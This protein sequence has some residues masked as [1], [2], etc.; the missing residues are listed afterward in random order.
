MSAIHIVFHNRKKLFMVDA[1]EVQ[2]SIPDSQTTLKIFLDELNTLEKKARTRLPWWFWVILALYFASFAIVIVFVWYILIACTVGIVLIL[3]ILFVH[4]VK[5]WRILR[6]DVHILCENYKSVFR[7][8]Y[9]VKN[10]FIDDSLPPEEHDFEGLA[11]LL[12]PIDEKEF[13]KVRVYG[14]KPV[15]VNNEGEY[16][17]E[18][19]LDPE[20]RKMTREE[21]K[22]NRQILNSR[23]ER[24]S[25]LS[26]NQFI[27][28]DTLI[29]SERLLLTNQNI[30]SLEDINE[31]GEDNPPNERT[32]NQRLQ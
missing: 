13:D 21:R 3:V 8:H 1:Q 14:E 31:Y 19:Q 15:I 27:T 23:K 9:F 11:I 24:N 2:L 18:R 28:L 26:S 20:N 6:F 7:P 10:Y 30:P 5:S 12:L 17:D 16:L 22:S 29:S 4:K 25:R 32:S